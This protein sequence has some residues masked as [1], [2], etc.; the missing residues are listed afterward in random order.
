MKYLPGDRVEV[1]V[2]NYFVPV[3]TKGVVKGYGSGRWVAVEV[4]IEDDKVAKELHDCDG[5]TKSGR[6]LYL[7]ETEI[8]KEGAPDVSEI[9]I[10]SGE[11]IPEENELIIMKKKLDSIKNAYK[12][13]AQYI[14]NGDSA[15]LFADEK[16]ISLKEELEELLFKAL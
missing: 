14:F 4:E 12:N 1:I 6:G 5:L 11:E 2:D 10:A 15:S 16:F 7:F 8:K 13:F 3:G 9:T